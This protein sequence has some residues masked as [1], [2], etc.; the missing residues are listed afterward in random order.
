[1][2]N[3]D[4]SQPQPPPPP[5]PSAPRRAGLGLPLIAIIGL[6]LLA[7]PRVVFH[8]LG[9]IAEGT[10]INALLVFLPPVIWIVVVVWRRVPNPFLTLLVVGACYGVLLALGHQLLWGVSFGDAVPRLGGNLT[11]LDPVMQSIII[12]S[13]ATV[14]SLFTGVIV[15]AIAGLVAWGISA[16]MRSRK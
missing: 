14:S 12:R 16:V 9:L 10:P 11:A 6:A 15:G 5:Q 4:S 8:D 2:T 13:F 1:M 7:V 3:F